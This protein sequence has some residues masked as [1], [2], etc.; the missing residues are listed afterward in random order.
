MDPKIQR[1]EGIHMLSLMGRMSYIGQLQIHWLGAI[2]FFEI[3]G[4]PFP[5]HDG[6]APET[7]GLFGPAAV[8]EWRPAAPDEIAIVEAGKRRREEREAEAAENERWLR[9][10]AKN[11]R[12]AR[13]AADDMV[14]LCGA[15][16]GAFVESKDF[17]AAE[18][19]CP[20]CEEH[21][22]DIPF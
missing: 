11:Y 3:L 20:K 21:L 18:S 12:H 8:F 5:C 9:E 14:G 1:F 16:L 6:L 17:G 13:V 15:R 7:F 2:P 10:E 4:R 19:P 22:D